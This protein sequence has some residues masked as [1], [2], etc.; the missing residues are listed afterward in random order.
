MPLEDPAGLDGPRVF[1]H[2]VAVRFSRPRCASATVIAPSPMLADM[3]VKG[4]LDTAEVVHNQ[5]IGRLETAD[6]IA[7]AFLSLCSPGS[8]FDALGAVVT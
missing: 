4:E 2:A 3:I 8:S 6:E 5:P 7:A 1:T